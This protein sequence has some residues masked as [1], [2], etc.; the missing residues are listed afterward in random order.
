M[1]RKWRYLSERKSGDY[2]YVRDFPTSL[3]RTFPDHPKQFSKEL[4][5]NS[6]C[7]DSELHRAM[8]EASRLYELRV[9][10]ALNSDPEAFSDSE[11][12]MAVEEVLR[13]RKLKPGEYAHVPKSQYSEEEWQRA[14]Q[15]GATIVPDRHDLA[16]W[17]IPEIE[18]IGDDI[19]RGQKLSFE[20]QV[21]LDAWQSIQELPKFRNQKICS[22]ASASNSFNFSTAAHGSTKKNSLRL[23]IRLTRD[24]S[25]SSCS[26]FSS[27]GASEL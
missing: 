26:F 24:S 4:Y 9:K 16:E 17:A 11:L 10:T 12:K 15:H 19:N 3:L 25:N 7:T 27:A 5:L 8:D 18:D 6:S 2:R 1:K 23:L 13:Q 21:Y 20:Q 22:S 14:M